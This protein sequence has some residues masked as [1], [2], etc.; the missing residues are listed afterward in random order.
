MPAPRRS[1]KWR[2]AVVLVGILAAAAATVVLY[3][4]W[5]SHDS[6]WLLMQART[7]ALSDLQPPMMP[8]TWS[9]LLQQGLPPGSLLVAQFAVLALG[10]AMLGMAVRPLLALL[11]PLVML[12]P[13]FLVLLGHLWIDVTMAAALAAAAGWIALSGAGLHARYAWLAVLPLSYAIAVRHNAAAAAVPLLYVMVSRASGAPRSATAR[14]GVTLALVAG[15]IGASAFLARQVVVMPMPAWTSTAI[16]DLSAA[17][18]ASER[19]LLPDGMRGPSLTVEELRPLVNADTSMDI[20]TG[21]KSGVNP[22]VDSPLPPQ[23][24]RELLA[25]WA[26]LPFTHTAAWLR[27]RAAVAWSLLGP[28]RRDKWESLFIIPRVIQYADN[29]P[30]KVNDTRLNALLLEWSRSARE[31]PLFM[32]LTYLL[33][34]VAG[35]ALSLRPRFGGDRPLIAALAASAWA[36]ALP[37]V[38]IVPAA[39][40]RYLLWPMMAGLLAF[41]LSLDAAGPAARARP[42]AIT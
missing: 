31:T 35:V 11:L 16:W 6:A 4:G 37:L 2:P 14:A 1:W 7:R 38:L 15:A 9:F 5:Y 33:L 10:L 41:L 20:L 28:Q 13:P 25:A 40:L 18:V 8:L 34:A 22:G 3:P 32:P 17:S 30:M 26:R 24:E 42:S 29:P 21:T 39:E 12:W 19:M 27:H 23:V 36:H